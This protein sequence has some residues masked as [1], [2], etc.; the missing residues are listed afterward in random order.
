[1]AA[2]R[3]LS[4]SGVVCVMPGADL[5]SACIYGYYKHVIYCTPPYS[6]MCFGSTCCKST[7]GPPIRLS[8]F[9]CSCVGNLL[10]NVPACGISNRYR[11]QSVGFALPA[12]YMQ[13]P[14]D[15]FCRISCTDFLLLLFFLSPWACSPSLAQ[16]SPAFL[17]VTTA[18]IDF[19]LPPL[20]QMFALSVV[21]TF[22][23]AHCFFPTSPSTLVRLM[24]GPL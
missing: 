5:S 9:S 18:A 6:S 23:L 11:S 10:P 4:P 20:L 15:L 19:V 8:P 24:C 21:P 2:K 14:S 7:L 3:F 17:T 16:A 13:P 22:L 1:M 12:Y